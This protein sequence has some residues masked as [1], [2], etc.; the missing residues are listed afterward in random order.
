[1]K[2]LRLSVPKDSVDAIA[3]LDEVQG[4]VLNELDEARALA[5]FDAR[6]DG[7]FEDALRA[8]I[9]SRKRALAMVRCLNDRMGRPMRWRDGLDASSSF[10]PDA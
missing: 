1:M 10:R 7:R 4:V 9:T 6:L 8:G 3:Y 5:Y 2:V